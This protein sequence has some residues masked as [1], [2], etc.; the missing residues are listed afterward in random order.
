M[1][2]KLFPLG[3]FIKGIAADDRGVIYASTSS[4]LFEYNMTED[5]WT[6]IWTDTEVD[7]E[8]RIIG[9]FAQNH[10]YFKP[11]DEEQEEVEDDNIDEDS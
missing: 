3:K 10:W 9:I 8:K 7:N 11:K 1:L 6:R 4:S 5:K 2:S